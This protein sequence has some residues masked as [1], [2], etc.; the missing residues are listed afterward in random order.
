MEGRGLPGLQ[1]SRTARDSVLGDVVA[2]S[3]GSEFSSQDL[4]W[5]L[6]TQHQLRHQM[7]FPGSMDTPPHIWHAHRH[8]NKNNINLFKQKCKETVN[9]IKTD[10][11]F[12]LNNY[13]ILCE[14]YFLA[15]MYDT[16]CMP[17]TRGVR[18]GQVPW[19]QSYRWS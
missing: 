17:S 15:C 10:R 14:W 1:R 2:T 8:V 19:K 12:L 11:M 13:L 18:R 9:Q 5:R 6:I 16:T 7:P 3:R 4:P